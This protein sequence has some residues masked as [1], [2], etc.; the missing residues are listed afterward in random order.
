VLWSARNGQRDLGLREKWS[1]SDLWFSWIE[2][3]EAAF[4]IVVKRHR[5]AVF[6][7]ARRHVDQIADADDVAAITF[8]ELWLH[9]KRV[10]L[11]DGS[12]RPWLL[13]TAVNVARN[14]DRSSRRYLRLLA[15]LPPAEHHR[16]HAVDVAERLDEREHTRPVTECL[17]TLN[18]AERT[19]LELCIVRELSYWAVAELLS[20]PIGTV[21]SRL[22]RARRTLRE[23]LGEHPEFDREA[24]FSAD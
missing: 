3:D 13:A 11:R 16:D 9:R 17:A 24:K 15:A 5:P 12:L 7:C 14:H 2:G 19:V 1:D 20:V 18:D 10:C 8:L 22:H 4:R 21:K 23:R 6:V